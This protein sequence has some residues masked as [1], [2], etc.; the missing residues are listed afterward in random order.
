MDNEARAERFRD[1]VS[2]YIEQHGDAGEEETVTDI[3]TDCMHAIGLE[4]FTEAESMAQIHYY[5]ERDEQ[6]DMDR[7]ARERGTL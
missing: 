4:A 1:L 5:A 7:S 3:L 2:H 6:D